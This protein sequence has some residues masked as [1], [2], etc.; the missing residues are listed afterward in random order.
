LQTTNALEWKKPEEPKNDKY[1]PKTYTFDVSKCEE[2][3]DLLVTDGIILVPPNVKL[4]PLEQRKKRGFCKFHGFLGH[5]LSRCTRFRDSVLKALDEG[6][7]KFGDKAK[8]PMQVDEDPLKKADSMYVEIIG[9]NM[10]D[11]VEDSGGQLPVEKPAFGENPQAMDEMVTEDH[12]STNALITEDQLIKKMEVAYPKA[13]EDLIDFLNRCKISNTNAMLCPRCN[14]IFDKEAEKSV[15]GFLPHTEHKSR[16]VENRPK[17]GFNK[18]GV[19]YKMKPSGQSSGRTHKGTFNPPPKSP[20]DTWVFSGGKKTGHATPPTKWVRRMATT[21]HQKEASNAKQYAYNNNYKGKHPMTKTQ[22]R[23]Y[24]RHKKVNALKEITNVGR[25]EGKQ[26]AVFKMVKRPAT[27]RIFPP[28]PILEKNCLEDDDEMTSNFSGSDPSFD[29]ICV[30]SMLPIE[31][32]VPSEVSDVESDFTE[33]MAIHRPLC[34]YVMNN[35]CVEDQ[36]TLFKWSVV[37]MRL[38]LKPLFIQAKINGVGVN[39][40]LV[41]GGAIVNLLPSRS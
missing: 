25:E 36:H 3:F 34:Y 40:V 15:E 32:D 12:Q 21:P 5:N 35:G 9:I 29:V 23:R 2:I 39:K 31:Y 11:I 14:A 7:L 6:R 38:H 13:E 24:Q 20:T 16:W 22:W 27:E 37:S 30:V 8:Q 4:P 33:E 10:V 18:R 19:P 26:E 1:P 41:D 17:Y 28:L